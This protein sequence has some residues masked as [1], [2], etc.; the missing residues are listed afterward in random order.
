MNLYLLERRSVCRYTPLIRSNAHRNTFTTMKH[1]II[2][3][4]NNH[5]LIRYDQ[6]HHLWE[7]TSSPH[8]LH[9][10]NQSFTYKTM[11]VNGD[12]PLLQSLVQRPKHDGQTTS[13]SPGHSLRRGTT[14][15]SAH[16]A[17]PMQDQPLFGPRRWPII[18]RSHKSVFCSA[19]LKIK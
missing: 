5:L 9:T 1:H 19:W 17:V 4:T 16:L 10:K 14:P 8:F 3:S 7:I 15:T 12:A 2:Q 11:A 6:W 18:R 13:P